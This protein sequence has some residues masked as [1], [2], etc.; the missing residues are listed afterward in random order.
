M[1]L[2]I[3]QEARPADAMVLAEALRDGA[4]GVPPPGADSPNFATSAAT[5]VVSDDETAATRLAPRAPGP[6]TAQSRAPRQVPARR[7]PRAEPASARR[8]A[9]PQRAPQRSSGRG[10][11][12]LI[13]LLL[14]VGVLA[15]IVIAAVVISNSTSNMVVHYKQVVSNDAQSAIHQLQS[16]VN[17]YTK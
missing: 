8:P 9:A 16:L 6:S 14:L 11:R 3:D 13:G 7:A 4:R 17:K 5:R 15:L 12:R 1:T 2:A 10:F